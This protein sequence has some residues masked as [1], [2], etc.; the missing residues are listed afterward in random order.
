MFT[1]QAICALAD[2]PVERFKSLVRRDQLPTINVPIGG[3]SDAARDAAKEPGW[4]RFSAE[5]AFMIAVQEGL[6]R[7][8]G[9]A[10]GLSYSSQTASRIVANNRDAI[11]DVLK[12]PSHAHSKDRWLG[13]AGA[14]VDKRASG[15][16][17]GGRNVSGILK[18]VLE[19]LA[20]DEDGY[21]RLFL[22]NADAVLREVQARAEKDLKIDFIASAR[23]EM[24]DSARN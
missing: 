17:P 16:N 3:I 1:R 21:T 13:Y 11:Q 12:S 7:Q 6:S 20:R 14:S 10:D 5:D 22:V 15:E 8:I 9:Y 23:L 19:T 18:E 4:N 2:I 24:M